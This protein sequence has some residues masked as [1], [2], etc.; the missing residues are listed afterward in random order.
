MLSQF[1]PQIASQDKIADAST[2][3]FFLW[4]GLKSA[5]FNST[6]LKSN[7]VLHFVVLNRDY[8]FNSFH[9]VVLHQL[10]QSHIKAMHRRG[11]YL[12]AIWGK[13]YRS[14]HSF[15]KEKM[16][17]MSWQALNINWDVYKWCRCSVKNLH[18]LYRWWGNRLLCEQG[19]K[20]L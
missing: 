8:I 13:I 6:T 12:Q 9:P 19:D 1:Y 17:E 10:S 11:K 4:D 2:R 18:N 15:N 7:L 3:I 20:H 16:K 5:I 14:P